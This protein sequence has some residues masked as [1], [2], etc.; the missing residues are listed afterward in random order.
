MLTK[1]ISPE[2]IR[3]D[4]RALNFLEPIGEHPAK[5]LYERLKH[6][7]CELS[8]LDEYLSDYDEQRGLALGKLLQIVRWYGRPELVEM[9]IPGL[10][11]AAEPAIRALLALFKH[12]HDEGGPDYTNVPIDTLPSVQKFRSTQSLQQIGR[13]SLVKDM[14]DDTH[15]S[16]LSDGAVLRKLAARIYD[17][18]ERF[19]AW[20][21][22]SYY[23][24]DDRSSLRSFDTYRQDIANI[25]FCAGLI[26]EH[27]AVCDRSLMHELKEL[28]LEIRQTGTTQTIRELVCSHDKSLKQLASDWENHY[29]GHE[30]VRIIHFLRQSFGLDVVR[31]VPIRIKEINKSFVG[32]YYDGRSYHLHYQEANENISLKIMLS[33]DRIAEGRLVQYH[34][35]EGL[36]ARL[37]LSADGIPYAAWLELES[38]TASPII[39]PVPGR[40]TIDPFGRVGDLHAGEIVGFGCSVHHGAFALALAELAALG[41]GKTELQKVKRAF[42]RINKGVHERYDLADYQLAMTLAAFKENRMLTITDYLADQP[43]SIFDAERLHLNAYRQP[44]K[45]SI[46]WAESQSARL[47]FGYPELY[48]YHAGDSLDPRCCWYDGTSVSALGGAGAMSWQMFSA[49]KTPKVNLQAKQR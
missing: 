44:G 5:S 23:V 29:P 25:I 8:A 28:A 45:K 26:V 42:M 36:T 22:A 14:L 19:K 10:V 32:S 39:I 34:V 48:P 41:A 13:L 43:E 24:P 6:A 18:Q 2:I 4:K 7:Q 17:D 49:I 3:L 46:F 30:R 9:V 38:P 47:A 27:E 40:G 1:N 15:V 33:S 11:G 31:P 16:S 12:I 21:N 20:G 37:P 35:I